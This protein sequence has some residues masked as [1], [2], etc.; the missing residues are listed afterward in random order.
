MSKVTECADSGTGFSRRDFVPDHERQVRM[1]TGVCKT[2]SVESV[3]LDG[4]CLLHEVAGESEGGGE[5][6]GKGIEGGSF[7]NCCEERERES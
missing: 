5:M 1:S 3:L 7:S 4:F 6:L 2:A